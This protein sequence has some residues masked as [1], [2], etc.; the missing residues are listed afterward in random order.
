MNDDPALVQSIRQRL[1]NHARKSGQ[2]IQRTLVR[3]ALERLLYRL[4]ISD[5]RDRFI[6][7]GAMLFS[8]WDGAPFRATGDLDLLGNGPNTE[9]ALA[10]VFREICAIKVA[11]PD[12]LNFN[13]DAINTA[14]L[15]LATDYSGVALRFDAMLG[16][17]RLRMQVDIGFGDAVIPEPIEVKFPTILHMPAPNLRAYP[18]ETVIAEKLEAMVS[19]GVATTR[20]KDFFDVWAISQSFDFESPTLIAALK[21]TFNRRG[22]IIPASEPV[23]LSDLFARDADKQ[24]LWAAFA[25]DRID[26]TAAPQD[27]TGLI[28]EIRMFTTPLL[29]AIANDGPRMRWDCRA[30]KWL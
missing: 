1:E 20:I 3:Y 14:Q 12:G 24:R 28:T 25:S 8:V 26:A 6:L 17:A 10:K 23:A 4:S 19:L 27:L 16:R 13:T 5:H 21:A 2:D 30:G 15:R 29:A 9:E 18:P 22:T 11:E 7:K